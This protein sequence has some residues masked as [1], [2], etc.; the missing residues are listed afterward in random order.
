MALL[1]TRV[2]KVNGVQRRVTLALAVAGLVVAAAIGGAA[3]G[4]SSRGRA[5][6]SG[7]IPGVS[8][9]PARFESLTGQKSLVV[10]AF[11][12][13]GQ[14]VS[15]GSPF[16]SLFPTLAPIPMI[17][18]GTSGRD[19][20]EAITP[21]G[22]AAG[23]GDAYLIALNQA[24]AAWGKGIYIRPMAEMNNPGNLYAAYGANGAAR[25]AAHSPASYRKAFARIYLILH[26]GTTGQVDAEL[27]ALGLSPVAKG[28]LADNAFPR[29]RVVWSPLA[30]GTPN[31][32]GNA[33]AMYYPGMAYVDV[34]GAD[35]YDEALTDTAPW[36][37]LEALYRLAL[38]H[39]KPFS[40]PEWGLIGV[41]DP[42]FVKHM[43]TFL[44]SHRA[45]EMQAYFE[46]NPG[47]RLDLA[48]K[49]KSK[50]AYRQCLTPLA[51][52]LPGWAA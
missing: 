17:H 43:C 35:I 1:G 24:I 38:S 29:L 13:W 7:P 15:F 50:A 37:D 18:L 16:A 28:E 33:P 12:A 5:A 19:G 25:N 10:Q 11:L 27:R 32:P 42:A 6:A 36:S 46:G 4:H 47:S 40:V 48:T 52:P 34:D 30:G 14:G 41:D 2:G 21:A 22:I 9:N 26:G 31:V 45:T 8:G 44:S 3:T 51:G 49:P 23:R 20:R 39:H